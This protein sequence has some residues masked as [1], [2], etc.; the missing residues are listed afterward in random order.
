MHGLEC[1]PPALDVQT[2][3]IHHAVGALDGSRHRAILM[4]VGAYGLHLRII[5]AEQSTAAIGMA[6]RDPHR[7]S[8]LPQAPNHTAAEK[9][10]ST[11]HRNRPGHAST[12][13]EPR[14]RAAAPLLG[15]KSAHARSVPR[16]RRDRRG[17]A[18]QDGLAL[19]TPI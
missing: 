7:E 15:Y 16:G 1:L 14:C 12:R 6:G 17:R 19:G 9:A 2:D 13:R 18:D 10:G 3:R 11:E 4:D 8:L 5:A